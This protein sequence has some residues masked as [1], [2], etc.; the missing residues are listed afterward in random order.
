MQEGEK[1]IGEKREER[2]KEN[3]G[4]NQDS[5]HNVHPLGRSQKS[6]KCNNTHYEK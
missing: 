1:R 6:N 3:L 4:Y 2:K 5:R